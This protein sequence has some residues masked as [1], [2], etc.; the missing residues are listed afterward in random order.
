MM[1]ILK[2]MSAIFIVIFI[3]G[4]LYFLFQQKEEVRE[5]IIYFPIDRQ[6]QFQQASTKLSLLDQHDED[7]YA[8]KWNVQSKL[9]RTAYL[10]QDIS[11]LFEDGILISTL[12]KWKENIQTIKMKKMMNGEDSSYYEAISFHHGELHYPDDIIKS[13]QRMSFDYLYVIDSPMSPLESFKIPKTSFELEWKAILNNT[14]N[15]QLQYIWS[16]LIQHYNISTKNYYFIAL[17]SVPAY[18]DNTFPNLSYEQ[19]EKAIGGL[20]EGLYKNYFLGIKNEDGTITSPIGSSIP[21][22]LFSKD[23][24]HFIILIEAKNG[25]KYQFIQQI[26]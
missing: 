7:E 25:K 15:Q 10:R 21:L 8:V 14:R 24:S 11:L 5:S 6:V 16:N 18:Q 12:S 23:G 17:T 22:I 2:K 1:H 19:T 20:W 9:D 26:T 13:S 3:C 4:V